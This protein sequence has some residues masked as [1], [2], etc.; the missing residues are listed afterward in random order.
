[1]IQAMECRVPLLEREQAF[2]QIQKIFDSEQARLG[3]ARNL[4]RAVAHS[5]A[6]W[7]T[8]SRAI[9]VYLALRRI[10]KRLRDLLCLYT[11][12]LNGC[13]YC[14]DDAAGEALLNG[15]SVDELR[16]LAGELSDAFGAAELAALRYAEAVTCNPNEID[17]QVLQP[18]RA[19]FD[20]EEILEIT[21]I[22]SMKNFWNK[23][24]SALQIPS[25]GHCAATDLVQ[26]LAQASALLRQ[27]AGGQYESY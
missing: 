4:T 20:T 22:V 6:A 19:H 8:T 17:D 9:Q 13:L 3:K 12:M 1:M 15:W 26:H 11:S 24:A 7:Q 18:L 10:D 21:V 14:I 25:E 27:G 2:E 5:P 16:G 23:F